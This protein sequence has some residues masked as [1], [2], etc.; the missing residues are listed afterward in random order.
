[1]IPSATSPAFCCKPL[2]NPP[3]P[4]FCSSLILTNPVK[5]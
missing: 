5:S 2:T 3:I 1:L 4:D